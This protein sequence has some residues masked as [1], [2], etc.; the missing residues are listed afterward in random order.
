MYF[1]FHFIKLVMKLKI[2]IPG[3]GESDAGWWRTKKMFG[4][5]HGARYLTGENLEVVWDEFPTL[6]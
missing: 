2:F 3:S 1:F 4:L 6:S 5:S